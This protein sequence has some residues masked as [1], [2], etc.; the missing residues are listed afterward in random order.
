[1]FSTEAFWIGLIIGAGSCSMSIVLLFII[2]FFLSW[3]EEREN[4]SSQKT[5]Q[6][7]EFGWEITGH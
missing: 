4:N 5:D 7:V 1:M 2:M 3:K 6:S